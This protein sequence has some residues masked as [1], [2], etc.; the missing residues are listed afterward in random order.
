MTLKRGLGVESADI[1]ADVA[2][3]ESRNP[4]LGHTEDSLIL[5]SLQL[6]RCLACAIIVPKCGQV[7]VLQEMT[8][9]TPTGSFSVTGVVC[10][11]KHKRMRPWDKADSQGGKVLCG[12]I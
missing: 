4:I 7:V 1:S 2:A 10:Y 5:S 6:Q 3:L 12:H 9:I 11:L 8:S